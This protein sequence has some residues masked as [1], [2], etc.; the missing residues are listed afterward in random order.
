MTKLL[1]KKF[2]N[3]SDEL[4]AVFD[5]FTADKIIEEDKTKNVFGGMFSNRN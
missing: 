1:P 3:L 4:K 5:Q 2:R